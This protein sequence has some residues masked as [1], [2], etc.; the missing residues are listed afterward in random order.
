MLVIHT[1]PN[2]R[3]QYH[4]EIEDDKGVI[5]NINSKDRQCNRQKIAAK[6]TN[7]CPQNT[8]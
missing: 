2:L 1:Y 4:E 3:I 7:N 5:R 8:S 6:R